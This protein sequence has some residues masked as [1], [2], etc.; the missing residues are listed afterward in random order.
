MFK[1]T[2]LFLTLSGL[3]AVP[4]AAPR[5]KPSTNHKHIPE[6]IP[7]VPANVPAQKNGGGWVRVEESLSSHPLPD[8]FRQGTERFLPIPDGFRQGTERSMAIPDGFKQGTEPF[9]SIRD[10]FKQGTEPFVSIRDGFKQG[11]EP[12][13]SIEHGFRQGTEPFM[14]V[15]HG[16]RQE[17]EPTN[18]RAACKG[19]V[20]D[21]KCF[22]SNPL[23]MN[24]EE[25]VNQQQ[26][27]HLNKRD[28]APDHSHQGSVPDGFKQ[29]T[30][31]RITI[32]DGFRQGTERFMPIKDDFRQGTE[33]HIMIRDGFKQ[34]TEPRITIRDGFRQGTE[35][36][37]PIHDD[38]QQG[39]E[40]FKSFQYVFRQ[41]T[42][43]DRKNMMC[44]GGA[45]R[46]ICYVFNPTSLTFYDAQNVCKD[47]APNAK[48]ASVNSSYLHKHLVSLVTKG[49]KNKPVATWLGGTIKNQKASWEDGSEWKYSR[50]M[51][52]YPNIHTDKPLCVEMFEKG[53]SSWTTAD[54]HQMRASICSYPMTA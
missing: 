44:K 30:E 24:Y 18:K 29:N 36:F 50:W 54:C 46:G 13:V 16:P 10:G 20:I 32:R 21:G 17:A 14:F 11:T 49:G 2:L 12:F 15:Q 33:P 35:R 38:F 6:H 27:K 3:Q 37:L 40:S 8:G 26:A 22:E 28:V 41:G 52:G 48:L 9:I 1:L 42:E 45:I 4:I 51:P 31:P 19:K 7:K 43:P 47:L 25:K 39:T 53:A 34:G 5:Q 23:P